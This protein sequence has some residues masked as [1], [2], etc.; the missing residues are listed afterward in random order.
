MNGTAINFSTDPEFPLFADGMP[1]SLVKIAKRVQW[2]RG[3]CRFYPF[4][5]CLNHFLQKGVK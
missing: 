5:F 2:D 4:S 3:Y 1:K